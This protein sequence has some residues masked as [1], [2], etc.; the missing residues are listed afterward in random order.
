MN[1]TSLDCIE[2]SFE[3][4]VGLYK[5]LYENTQTFQ[6]IIYR[7]KKQLTDFGFVSAFFWFRFRWF[8]FWRSLRTCCSIRAFSAIL[9]K[10]DFNFFCCWNS[11]TKLFWPARLEQ[12]TFEWLKILGCTYCFLEFFF[13]IFKF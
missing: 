12:C 8:C 11:R 4:N 1:L 5:F 13:L 3:Q 2:C 9:R 6:S 10:T 7:Q